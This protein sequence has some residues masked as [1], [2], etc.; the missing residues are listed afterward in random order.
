MAYFKEE[1]RRKNLKVMTMFSSSAYISVRE[2]AC[3]YAR[4]KKERTS[5]A[6]KLRMEI[7]SSEA[8]AA[9]PNLHDSHGKS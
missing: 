1:I 6:E 3:V 9:G 8:T 2:L 4:R 5:K 7:M